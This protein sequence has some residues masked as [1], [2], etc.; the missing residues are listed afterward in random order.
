MRCLP[1]TQVDA[2]T[3]RPFGGNP[4]AVYLLAEP[5]SEELMQA[6]ANEMNL[7]ETAFVAPPDEHGVRRLRWFTPECE[8]P[9][10]GHATLAAAHALRE[11]GDGP[12]P[13]R[14]AT[15]S[16]ELRVEA[17]S[18][19]ALTLDFPADPP[20]E[21]EPPTGLL[22]A[23]GCPAPVSVHR[24]Q[25]SWI[26]RAADERAVLDTRPD[27]AALRGFDLGPLAVILSVTAPSDRSGV[28][29]AS[30]VFAP[31]AGIDEDPV[32]GAAHTTLT[33]YWCAELGREALAA[34]Q[35]SAR[36]GALKVAL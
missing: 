13:L 33:P 11:A 5:L 25:R 28:D 2:F 19:G 9:L 21:V 32:T 4:A 30:R 17:D 22:E 36:R 26:V 31:W 20:A 18:D 35:I 14:F 10:C 12:F 1:F 29:F 7:S 34:E 6:I 23:V 8:V 3:S 16:G 15:R 27:F 24:G